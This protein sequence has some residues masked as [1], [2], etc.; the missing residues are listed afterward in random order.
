MELIIV[1]HGETDKNTRG[2]LLGVTDAGLNEKGMIEVYAAA[3][4]IKGIRID[5]I[6][7][8]PLKRAVQTAGIICDKVDC[9]RVIVAENIKERNFGDWDGL[10]LDEIRLLYPREYDL[11]IND[12]DYCMKGAESISNMKKRIKAFLDDLRNLPP[13]SIHVIVTHLGCIRYMLAFLLGLP[14]EFSWRFRVD[15][16]GIT[17]VEINNEGYAFLTM[18]NG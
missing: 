12:C 8:S 3:E 7:T 15:S 10:S 1:R 16:G 9:Q 17:K 5:S 6:Y 11:W 18:L 4:K 14:D 2:C 13:D